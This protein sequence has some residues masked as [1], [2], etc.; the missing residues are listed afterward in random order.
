M[1][2]VRFA[3]RTFLRRPAL[4]LALAAAL[5]AGLGAA[6]AAWSLV[7]RAILRKPDLPDSSRLIIGRE[8][9]RRD[10]AAENL[11]PP[12]DVLDWSDSGAFSSLGAWMKWNS[13]LTGTPAPQRLAIALV[14]GAYFPTLGK[15]AALGR[16]LLPEDAVAGKDDVVVISDHLWRSV[17]AAD[18][19]IL[20][21]RIILNGSPVTV[22]GVMPPGFA[23]PDDAV[24]VW[25][26]FVFGVHFQPTDR[27]G[28]NLRVVGRLRPGV[29]LAQANAILD[30]VMARTAKVSPK[31]HEGWAASLTTL[32]NETTKSYRPTVLLL[33]TAA[34]AMLAVAVANVLNLFLMLAASRAQ[35][36]ATRQAL[37]GRRGTLLR[38]AAV[39][40]LMLGGMAGGGAIG[41]AKLLLKIVA[42]TA[43]D[44]LPAASLTMSP[45][46]AALGMAS[47]LLIG[48]VSSFA[49]MT[50]FF[51]RNL[52][53]TIRAAQSLTHGRLRFRTALV[54][55][56]IALTTAILIPAGLL[57]GSFE[58][59][60]SVDPG[61]DGRHL[62]TA[63]V[64]LPSRYGDSARQYV[65][66]RTALEGVAAIP[67]VAAVATIQDL[68]LMR[69]AMTFDV[70][71]EA[72]GNVRTSS[73][74]YRVVSDR[75]FE[76]VGIPILRGRTFTPHDDEHA[77]AVVIVNRAL[78]V[79]ALGG[80]EA[81]GARMRIGADGPWATIVGVAGDVK[82]MGLEGE[83]VPAVYQPY[84]QKQ[85]AFLRWSTLVLRTV[86]PPT[87]ELVAA[88]RAA[89]LRVD[90]DQP[91][92]D[93]GTIDDIV[94]G[95]LA[96]PR[97]AATSVTS[98]GGVALLVAIIGVAGVLAYAVTLRGRE[99]GIRAALGAAP[100]DLL[101][102]VLRQAGM[103]AVAGIVAGLAVAVS[104]APLLD[105]LLFRTT[106]VDGRVY[107]AVS[108][109]LLLT[110]LGAALVPARRAART[111]PA[112]MLRAE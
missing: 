42:R 35:E 88:L 18:R 85:F 1:N 9:D 72:A 25:V 40:G 32:Q 66:F 48:A 19:G 68:P 53:G 110:A 78:A 67:G 105:R 2:E 59:L 13:T 100:S 23:Q 11:V 73:A 38:R 49:A 12:A 103:L 99:L 20:E 8:T 92:S 39:E 14:S 96:R 98:L 5:T 79:R 29:S 36:I 45:A 24:D 33:F 63:Q 54:V 95:E 44:V 74:A 52:A 43:G 71:L 102:L 91:L 50:L 86:A 6:L 27:V 82:Q 83:E 65:F 70:V 41:L 106:A 58:R 64:W 112:A 93:V 89:I 97:L 111:D 51:R 46:V 16:T 62:L 56:Q 4:S 3:L 84:A 60:A 87:P 7:D 10:P 30:A 57:I 21:R 31:T 26:P 61:F 34:V 109:V 81:L 17:F 80:A 22:A 77:P 101:A 15:A 90:P 75:Y 37:G 47:A 55:A 28:R 107:A 76:A 108:A 104:A 69:N 94:A